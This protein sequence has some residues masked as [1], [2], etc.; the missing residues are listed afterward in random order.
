MI[1]V[2][3]NLNTS[4]TT[5]S[6]NNSKNDVSNTSKTVAMNGIVH[7]QHGPIRTAAVE[8]EEQPINPALVT[9]ASTGDNSSSSSKRNSSSS[10]NPFSLNAT[11][12]VNN[13]SENTATQSTSSVPVADAQP[14]VMVS[15]TS[16]EYPTRPSRES[17]LQRLSEALL[18]RSLT[19]V[20]YCVCSFGTIYDQSSSC[21]R[22]SFD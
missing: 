11:A 13:S 2:I 16:E 1:D 20:R 15:L 5:A 9:T 14:L 12:S 6:T 8:Q 3:H 22:V 7:S 21:A 10:D 19:Q 18:R 4:A 17:V